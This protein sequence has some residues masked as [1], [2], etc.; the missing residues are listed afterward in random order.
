MFA[1]DEDYE[2]FL[3]RY[4]RYLYSYFITYAYCLIPNHFHFLIK[5]K[6]DIYNAIRNEKTKSA[7]KYISGTHSINDFIEHQMSR[8]F[9]GVALR[10]NHRMK[11]VGPL[12]KQ[13]IK[14]VLLKTDTRVIYQ[15]CYIHHNPIHHKLVNAYNNWKY[16]SYGAYTQ[17]RT[18][19]IAVNEMLEML[20]GLDVF[21][22]HHLD[23]K[24]NQ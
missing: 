12:F 18:T 11:R 6:E 24:K 19:K 10:Y 5:V 14:R 13:G 8:M 1:I 3:R 20:G 21:H 4:E 7:R 2:D 22:Y 23:H 9:S 17:K 15:L 16:S